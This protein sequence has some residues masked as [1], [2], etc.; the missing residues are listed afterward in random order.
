MNLQEFINA[1]H[2]LWRKHMP[3]CHLNM[4]RNDGS[5]NLKRENKNTVSISIE[6]FIANRDCEKT[7]YHTPLNDS[8]H[9]RFKLT[10]AS[11]KIPLISSMI[12]PTDLSLVLSNNSTLVS[13]GG[14]EINLKPLHITGDYSLI[15]SELDM[16]FLY[17]QDLCTRYLDV[18][19]K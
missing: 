16:Y 5:Y 10:S 6:P 2:K 14:D 12:L 7:W 15:L 4:V 17:L 11:N 18:S 13:K 9:C 3:N 1:T 19:T 8:L